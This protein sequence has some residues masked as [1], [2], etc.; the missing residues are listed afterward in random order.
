[1]G[2]RTAAGRVTVV[3]AR[4]EPGTVRLLKLGP[5][6][7]RLDGEHARAGVGT[8]VA[9]A[10]DVNGDGLADVL[11]GSPRTDPFGRADAGVAYVV[12]GGP[13][14]ERL[15]LALLGQRG[16]RI[17]GA[18]ADDRLGNAVAGLGDVSGDGRADLV[19]G[20]PRADGT[21]P[22]AGLAT[23]VFGPEP[24]PAPP[25]PPPVDPGAEEEEDLD[26]CT[27]A[28]NLEV[29]VDDSGSMLDTDPGRLRAKALE[30]LLAKERNAG[31]QLGAVEFGSLAELLFQPVVLGETPDAGRQVLRALIRERI[32]GDGGGTNYNRGFR[33]AQEVNPD[34][35]AIVFLTDGGHNEGRYAAL[36]QGGP[37]V[38]VIGLGIGAEG[39]LGARL[40]HMAEET[41]GRYFPGVGAERLQPVLNE[42]DSRLNCDIDLGTEADRVRDGRLPDEVAEPLEAGTHSTDVIV[43]W[44]D[45][46]DTFPLRSVVLRRGGRLVAGFAPGQLA[47]ALRG[48]EVHTGKGL[49]ITGGRGPTYLS[50]R[51]NGLRR[52]T[53]VVRFKRARLRGDGR[54]RVVTQIAESRRRR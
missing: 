35:G 27:A 37:P 25:P 31:E 46:R 38:Y 15:D 36:H 50:L 12:F 2:F 11:V 45:R 32:R 47:R 10:G 7:M 30:L 16:Y 17:A 3:F 42:I 49:R 24:P 54:E 14:V 41:D 39:P 19:V 44:D 43:S 53:L 8:A 20:S 26:G 13:R 22:D 48:R 28:T 34:A 6:G 4:S 52:G 23:V 9:G 21:A 18:A 5:D 33:A 29:I 1:M 40:R 51:V